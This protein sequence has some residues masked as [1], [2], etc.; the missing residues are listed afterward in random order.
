MK[1]RIAVSIASVALFLG[2]LVVAQAG[3]ATKT[4]SASG[5]S[6]TLTA[7]VRNAKTCDWSSRPKIAGF[8]KTVKCTTGTAARSATFK[9]NTSTTAKSYAITLIV[10]G[11]TTTVDHW[12]VIQAG[13][14]TTTTTTVPTPAPINL[15]G[16][17]QTATS[18]FTVESGLAVFQ[19]RC[20][21]CQANFIVEIDNANGSLVDIPI[22]VIGSYSG[23]IAEGLSAG[24]YILSVTA[25][26]GVPWTVEITQPR[27]VAGVALPTTLTGQGQEVVGPVA[28]GSSLRIQATNTATQ[29]G[30]F[31]IE[32]L[33]ANGS[34][35][36]IPINEIG[37]FSGST[38]ANFLSGG[39]YYLEINSDGAWSITVSSG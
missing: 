28:G 21:A 22:N 5:G 1:Y 16:T 19:A 10:R 13:K 27:G 35:Q 6:V 15:S 7:T 31:I 20:S 34:M 25:D 26:Q 9:A 39:P 23:S 24:Q 33:G 12:R 11:K 37:S 30:N 32:I 3:A 4:V 14:T 36:G 2:G 18:A 17:G 29:G 8:A 38:I